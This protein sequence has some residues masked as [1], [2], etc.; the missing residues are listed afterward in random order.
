MSVYPFSLLAIE[1]LS[2][3]RK[4]LTKSQISASGFKSPLRASNQSSLYQICLTDLEKNHFSSVQPPNWPCAILLGSGIFRSLLSPSYTQSLSTSR[5]NF[6]S[7]PHPAYKRTHSQNNSSLLT[8]TKPT[9][10]HTHR[11]YFLSTTTVMWAVSHLTLS[12]QKKKWNKAQRC[13]IDATS[14]DVSYQDTKLSRYEDI[15]I[16]WYQDM[17]II[18]NQD[19]EI[20]IKL[21]HPQSLAFLLTYSITHLKK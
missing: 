9:H 8:H 21:R 4:S 14:L 10:I 12:A 6:H 18:G 7:L 13:A 20:D 17:K 2:G 11:M 16:K 19:R 15:K 3:L 5:F 1:A